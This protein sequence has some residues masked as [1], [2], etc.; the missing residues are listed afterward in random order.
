M[1][2]PTEGLTRADLDALGSALELVW[3]AARI[4]TVAAS[5]IPGIDLDTPPS[6]PWIRELSTRRRIAQNL[7]QF[8]FGAY[9]F[10]PSPE[11]PWGVRI[12][13]P[14]ASEGPVLLTV[15]VAAP[16]KAARA[17]VLAG[18]RG[19]HGGS[20]E[21]LRAIS[22]GWRGV[23]RAQLDDRLC[24]VEEAADWARAR[25]DELAGSD[26]FPRR[27]PPRPPGSSGD[28]TG[29][30]GPT[31]SVFSR[32]RRPAPDLA[33]HLQLMLSLAAADSPGPLVRAAHDTE[34][35]AY[36]RIGHYATKLPALGRLPALEVPIGPGT[37]IEL[38]EGKAGPG[39]RSWQQ[40]HDAV[41]PDDGA[42]WADIRLF[43]VQ[44]G[45]AL[46]AASNHTDPDA[47][48]RA[49]LGL[50]RVKQVL[51]DT[52]GETRDTTH[53]TAGGWSELLGEWARSSDLIRW[54]SRDSVA[55]VDAGWMPV[56]GDLALAVELRTDPRRRAVREALLERAEAAGLRGDG[57]TLASQGYAAVATR[58]SGAHPRPVEWLAGRVAC[59][60][61]ACAGN[62]QPTDE[63]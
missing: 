62:D 2:G 30:S 36:P 17:E 43:L 41:L 38:V 12:G 55:Y 21:Q 45:L 7:A 15:E 20:W 22:A 10:R 50:A 60:L 29:R 48:R 34:H 28:E 47:L 35:V 25:V 4:A 1:T 49:Q 32:M 18:T 11:G 40:V 19:L 59:L 39:Q 14:H 42:I 53:W 33:E 16:S 26:L 6:T 3:R 56:D 37:R 27:L 54:G 46:R 61:A 63:R 9:D 52:V 44:S 58:T 51:D 57:W 13:Y 31:A 24:P 23:F 8:G 5:R